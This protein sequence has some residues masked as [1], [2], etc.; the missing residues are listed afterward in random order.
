MIHYPLEFQ[1]EA[2]TEGGIAQPWTTRVPSSDADLVCAIPSEFEGPG[3]G[4]S[5]EDFFARAA[6]K[7]FCA[8]FKVIAEKSR[9]TFGE[10]RVQGRVTVDRDEK[11]R[12]WVSAL[13]LVARCHRGPG[14]S[15]RLLRV[16]E[17][18]SQSCIV[19]HSLKTQVSFEFEI[20]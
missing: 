20:I 10:L 5:P 1:V 13:H 12:P 8:T 7:C 15:E 11:G 14:E 9:V 17:K 16:L 2:R 3:G 18:T 4:Y 19:L 6:A